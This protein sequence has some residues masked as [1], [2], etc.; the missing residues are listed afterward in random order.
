PHHLRTLT[1]SQPST[2]RRSRPQ[3]RHA[4]ALQSPPHALRAK[5]TAH[6][7]HQGAYGPFRR[8]PNDMH[9]AVK[10]C[11]RGM[12]NDSRLCLEC[13]GELPATATK[14][15]LF[16]TKNCGKRHHARTQ[17]AKTTMTEIDQLRAQL[18]TL[19]SELGRK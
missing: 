13:G 4:I 6:V 12:T 16:C 14:R 19:R 18:N 15:R 5:R 8:G 17:R 10:S 2:P 3:Q 7:L 1:H 9:A 11:R